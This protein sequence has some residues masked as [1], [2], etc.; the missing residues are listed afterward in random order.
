MG[1]SYTSKGAKP[2]FEFEIDGVPFV[3]TGGV[4]LLDMSELAKLAEVDVESAEGAAAIAELFKGALGRVEYDRFRQ[5]TRT[6]HTDPDTILEIMK[7]MVEHVTGG[8][9]RRSNSSAVGPIVI[10]GMSTVSSPSAGRELSDE[11]ILRIRATL[12]GLG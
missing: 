7:D 12:A 1:H 4:S 5:H 9:T 10:D 11:E 8:P 2:P 6:H 3:C